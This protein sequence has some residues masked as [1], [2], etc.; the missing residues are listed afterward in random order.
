C[1]ASRLAPRDGRPQGCILEGWRDTAHE[2]GERARARLSDGV[3]EA[4]RRLGSGFLAHPANRDLRAAVQSGDLAPTDY[5]QE[6]LRLVYRL[7]FL[8]TTEDRGLLHPA[9]AGEEARAL[10]A[11]GYALALLRERA[12]RRR[13]YD[14][15]ADLWQGLQVVFRGLARGAAPL[16]LPALGGLFLPDQCPHLDAAEIDNEHLLEAV[17]S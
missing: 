9:D 16:G 1:H 15:H 17:R 3:R 2:I 8:F 4:L 10:Y 12:L 11:E 5:F 14:R 6:L 7:L 13:H